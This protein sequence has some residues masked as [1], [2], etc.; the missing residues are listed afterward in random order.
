MS[1]Y[2]DGRSCEVNVNKKMLCNFYYSFIESLLTF[3]FI[4]SF[5]VLS[6]KD[7]NSLSSIVNTCS[8]ITGV[9]QRG[10]CS[11][12]EN[13]VA[14][15]AKIINIHPEHILSSEFRKLHTGYLLPQSNTN[16]NLKAFIPSGIRLLNT[17]TAHLD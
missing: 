3:S 14:T 7:R 15:K 12:W 9:R 2:V 6:I 10:L 13:Q 1:T 4:C 17:V 16:R 8:K 11:L 5:S